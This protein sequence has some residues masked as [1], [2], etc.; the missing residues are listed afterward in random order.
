MS[1]SAEHVIQE[2]DE[3]GTCFQNSYLEAM[4]TVQ[5]VPTHIVERLEGKLKSFWSSGNS[6]LHA[7]HDHRIASGTLLDRIAGI[8]WMRQN[9][10]NS[11]PEASSG[12]LTKDCVKPIIIR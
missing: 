4:Q 2:I 9:D 3:I 8:V 6:V 10:I 5:F 12:S 11:E 1:S 7:V